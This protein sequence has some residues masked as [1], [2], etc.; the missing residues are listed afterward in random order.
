[1]TMTRANKTF[2]ICASVVVLA[3][4]RIFIAPRLVNIPSV[5][6]SYE[7]VAHLVDGFLILV[8]VYDWHQELGPSRLYG[9]LGG[10][11]ALWELGWFVAQ[12][13]LF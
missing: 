9:I 13:L 5:E 8:P 4:G 1:M 12:K 2:L 7:A 6:G 10:A 3:L 11:F